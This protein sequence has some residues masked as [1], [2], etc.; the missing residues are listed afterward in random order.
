M[1]RLLLALVA[2]LA[3]AAGS[4]GAGA[5]W[6]SAREAQLWPILVQQS[7]GNL[8]LA[9]HQGQTRPL[10]TDAD[11]QTRL[12]L[13]AA[14]APDGNS[15]ALV[16]LRNA[17]QQRSAALEVLRLD[18]QRVTVYDDPTNSP[19]YLSWAPDSQKLAFLTSNESSMTLWAVPS[20]G[21]ASAEQI[22]QGE[23]FYFTWSPN[24][25][26]LLLHIGGGTPSDSLQLYRWGTAQPELIN[27]KPAMFNAPSWL[28][29]GEHAV[30]A[31]QQPSGPQLVTID[32]Q[33]DIV[34]QLVRLN[35]GT[36]FTVS[37]DASQVAYIALNGPTPGQLHVV[38]LD[39]RNDRSFNPAP[40][41]AFFWSA[42]GDKLAFLSMVDEVDTISTRQD[43]PHLRWNV[44]TVQDGKVESF[45]PFQPSTAFIDLLPYFDQYA[46]SIRLWDP[47]GR[48][49][50]YASTS[51]VFTL[52]VTTGQ[53]TRVSSGVLGMWMNK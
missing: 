29:N 33:G 13:F 14:P 52:D 18:G 6:H 28:L 35:G 2:L 48:H 25:K 9:N 21:S 50:L 4:A 1:R 8:L 42:K 43:F 44:L 11:G 47:T 22:A 45:Q 31:L 36:L 17:A 19:F 7:D 53:T 20:S 30:V 23:P 12:Y 26:Q 32:T 40:I 51:G 3:L 38:Q 34:Q 10:T 37:P 39:G 49:L 24:S 46:Q 41:F 16:A 27:A 5:W 15:I